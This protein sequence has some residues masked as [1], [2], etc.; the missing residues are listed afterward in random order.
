[1]LYTNV[2]EKS[3]F[4]ALNDVELQAVSGGDLA[5]NGCPSDTGRTTQDIISDVWG[6]NGPW[7]DGITVYGSWTTIA[8]GGD[9]EARKYA[10]ESIALF[11][12]GVYI[13]D[14][15]FT[16]GSSTSAD[17]SGSIELGKNGAGGSYDGGDSNGLNYDFIAP[18]ED[19]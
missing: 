2:I 13:G 12:D 8:L 18:P 19:Y 16:D 11:R 6:S 4:R 1:M 15:E 5:L 3:G 17:N 9:D 14:I 10:D 7:A